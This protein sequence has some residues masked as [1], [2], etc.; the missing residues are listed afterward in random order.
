[1][2]NIFEAI[3]ILVRLPFFWMYVMGIG[4]VALGGY[5]E[6]RRGRRKTNRKCKKIREGLK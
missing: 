1:M 3:A 4:I 5:A 2:M 6:L